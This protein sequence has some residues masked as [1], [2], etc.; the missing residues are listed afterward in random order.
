MYVHLNPVRIKALGLGKED[1]SREK[2][3][4]LP[5]EPKPELVLERLDV[6]RK[7]RWSSYPAYAGYVEK[8]SWLYCDELW[9]RGC[10]KEG[11]DPRKEYR[12]WLENYLKQGIEEKLLSRMTAA[13]AIGS[14]KFKNQVR[15]RVLK[16]AGEG[17][18]ERQW[19]RLLPFPEVIKAV[20]Q[21][22]EESWCDISTRRGGWARDLALYAGQRRCG[23][24]LKELG[25]HT[26]M[27]QQAVCNAVA[28]I[29]HRIEEDADLKGHLH[30]VLEIIGD[31]ER[32][33]HDCRLIYLFPA[34]S[35]P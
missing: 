24:S 19:R 34:N 35:N 30:R 16:N 20:E 17:T 28:R 33:W 11:L 27:K 22:A 1:R 25:S 29:E 23:L 18:D 2:K 15:R 6:L 10:D 12:E 5:E 4:M 21:V 7:H 32:L 26:G 9:R 8:P 31:I 3:G 13:M 14:T